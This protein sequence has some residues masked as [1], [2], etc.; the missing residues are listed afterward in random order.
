MTLSEFQKIRRIAFNYLQY[1]LYAL[2]AKQRFTQQ[3]AY[4]SFHFDIDQ[5][6]TPTQK[7]MARHTL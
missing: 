4:N 5:E 2:Q 3:R 1:E 7:Y 6:E